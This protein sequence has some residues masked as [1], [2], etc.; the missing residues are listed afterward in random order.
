MT[1]GVGATVNAGSTCGVSWIGWFG[2]RVN[3]AAGLGEGL[4]R[5]VGAAGLPAEVQ[6][7]RKNKMRIYAGQNRMDTSQYDFLYFTA[8]HKGCCA[9]NAEDAEAVSLMSLGEVGN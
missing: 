3:A 7:A 8:A 9:K 2:A 6:D 5:V 4:G 1:A